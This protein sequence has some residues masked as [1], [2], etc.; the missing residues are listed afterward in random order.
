MLLAEFK[1]ADLYS[2]IPFVAYLIGVFAIAVVSARYL[3]GRNFESEYYVGSRSFGPWVLAMSWVATMAS[4]GS[5]LGYPSLVYTYGWSMTLWV[6]GS[7]VTAIVGLGIVGKRINRLAR[8]TGALTRSFF[9][10]SANG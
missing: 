1:Q 7:C 10:S 6:S 9:R 4:G 3:K 8:Q 5:F 2:L